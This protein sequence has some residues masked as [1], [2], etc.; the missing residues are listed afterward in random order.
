MWFTVVERNEKE[1]QAP[2]KICVFARAEVASQIEEATCT[3]SS[4][5]ELGDV[6][7][8]ADGRPINVDDFIDS[9]K[10]GGTSVERRTLQ[11]Q[12]EKSGSMDTREATTKPALTTREKTN[13]RETPGETEHGIEIRSKYH[14]IIMS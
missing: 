2:K 9:R 5:H 11:A 6:F 12:N 8:N 1:S 7:E 14:N 10:D 4:D 13:G 3:I